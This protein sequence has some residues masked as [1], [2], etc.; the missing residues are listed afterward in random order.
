M[1]GELLQEVL[2]I[3]SATY[4]T[5]RMK[6]YL[7]QKGRAMGCEV[8]VDHGN[9][10]M[11]KGEADIYPCMVSHTDTVHDIL[12]DNEYKVVQASGALFGW[13]PI[14]NQFAGVG[15]DD[16][17]GIF[18]A[19]SVLS[20]LPVAKAVFFRDEEVGGDGV[21]KADMSFFDDCAFAL[22]CDRQ[23]NMDFVNRINGS[24]YGEEFAAAVAPILAHHRYKESSGGYTDVCTLKEKGLKIVAANMSCG[25]WNPHSDEE[26]VDLTDVADTLGL[27]YHIINQLG[28]Q[29]WLHTAED[30]YKKISTT[31]SQDWSVGWDRF[32]LADSYRKNGFD[33]HREETVYRPFVGEEETTEDVVPWYLQDDNY[34]PVDAYGYDAFDYA[35]A[36][37]GCPKCEQSLDYDDT[38]GLFYCWNCS[39]YV[40]QMKVPVTT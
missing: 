30:T 40:T 6:K 1:N 10:Y 8:R 20:T 24:L 37:E 21:D 29:Q 38:S 18:I 19:L 2:S 33:Y 35:L 5:K 12:P 25:Y 39:E 17:V 7:V 27:V 36:E 15:G 26:Y 23:G 11:T 9:V 32:K 31:F 28:N 14:K 13:N 34:G 22:E 16:K 4:K 3:Q